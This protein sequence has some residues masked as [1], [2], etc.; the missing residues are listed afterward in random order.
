MKKV[1]VFFTWRL[2]F[3]LIIAVLAVKF[4]PYKGSFPYK[5]NLPLYQ[6]PSFLYSFA[7]FD[8]LHYLSI[9]KK[10][11]QQ[12]QQVFF[13][14]YPILIRFFSGLFKG[15]YLI[16]GLFISNFSF[17][18]GLL[19]LYNLSKLSHDFNFNWTLLSLLS[20]PTA[21]FFN[22]VYTEGLFF[23]LF[24]TTLY[25][26]K[27]KSYLLAGFTAALSSITKLIGILLFLPFIF[28]FNRKID[29][30][31]IFAVC[32]FIGIFIFMVYLLKTTGDP[33]YFFHA[34]SS[35]NRS[36]NFILLPQV[37][38]RYLKIFFLSQFSFQYLI[39]LSEFTLFTFILIICSIDL[40]QTIKIKKKNYFYLS[41]VCFSIL[42]ILI[43]SSTGTFSSIPRYGLFSIS[44]FF[45]LSR[46]KNKTV[47]SLILIFFGLLQTIFLS[48]FIQ[49]YFIS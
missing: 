39:A 47:K 36:T 8:G 11:Y 31:I 9:A 26:L 4:I 14:L 24:S 7:N 2:L 18:I 21:F 22:S 37:Y 41:I 43:P 17:L 12:Y 1:F 29:K 15:N 49:G 28:S 40:I 45:Y 44:V 32:P 34:Q 13:P 5:E 35:F 30:R 3:I 42:N 10:N 25:L 33:F 20:F 48:F 23:M 27:K 6:L 38:F 46:L 16:S 19:M